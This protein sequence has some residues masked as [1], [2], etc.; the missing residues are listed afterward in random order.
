MF[1]II[2]W[3]YSSQLKRERLNSVLTDGCKFCSY[4]SVE[5]IHHANKRLHGARS[6]RRVPLDGDDEQ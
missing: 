2:Q 6:L 3:L 4:S 1:G 5:H